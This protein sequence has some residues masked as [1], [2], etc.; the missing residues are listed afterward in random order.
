MKTLTKDF[1]GLMFVSGMYNKEAVS[2]F[3]KEREKEYPFILLNIDGENFL[4]TNKKLFFETLDKIKNAKIEKIF[5]EKGII[6]FFMEKKIVKYNLTK[7]DL[8]IGKL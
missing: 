2:F 8:K 6:V 1:D 5:V 3:E 7:T 4:I